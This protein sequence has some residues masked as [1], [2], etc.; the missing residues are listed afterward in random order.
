MPHCT[1]SLHGTV[2]T[3]E[4]KN[5]ACMAPVLAQILMHNEPNASTQISDYIVINFKPVVFLKN[6]PPHVHIQ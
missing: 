5:T 1:V 2:E 3:E 6:T 4:R